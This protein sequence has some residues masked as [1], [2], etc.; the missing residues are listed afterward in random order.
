MSYDLVAEGDLD[1][2][3]LAS[4]ALDFDCADMFPIVDGDADAI[5]IAV[6]SKRTRMAGAEDQFRELV[7]M[8]RVMG[9]TIH[10]LHTGATIVDDAEVDDLVARI[11][12]G[13]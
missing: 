4:F 9:A 13:A 12:G 1:Y 2:V 5:G 11:F 6:L 3:E 7:G 10:D 8:L